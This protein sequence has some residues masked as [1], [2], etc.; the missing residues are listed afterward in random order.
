LLPGTGHG[1]SF[2]KQVIEIH[3]GRVGREATAEGNNF[4]FVLP[5]SSSRQSG[6]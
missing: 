6:P 5:L 2:V 4:F 1:L 3:G